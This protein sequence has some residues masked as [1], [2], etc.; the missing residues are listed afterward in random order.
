M[1]IVLVG[2]SMSSAYGVAKEIQFAKDN[3]VPCFGVYVDDANTASNLP[4]GLPRGRVIS[5]TWP[6]IA[7]AIDQMMTEGKNS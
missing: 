2:R 3:N 6:G 1:V 4:I 7:S 5:W